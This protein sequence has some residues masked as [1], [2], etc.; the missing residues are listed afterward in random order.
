[1]EVW[2]RFGV[3]LGLLGVLAGCEA[4]RPRRPLAQ[5]KSARWMAN[6]GLTVLDTLCVRLT[7]GALAV[8][9]ALLA[10]RQTWGV[11][12]LLHVPTWG[13]VLLSIIA[14][15]FAIYLQ[16]VAFHANP[17]LWRLH[18]VHHTDRDFDVTTGLR[19]HPVEIVLSML[20]KAAV[21]L[22]LGAHPAAVVAFEVLLNAT[23]QFNHSNVR[24]PA[25]LERWLR[26]VL[27]TPDVHRMHHSVL[28]EE[29]Q[30]NFGFSVPFW[31]RLCGTY[32]ERPARP[33]TTMPLGVEGYQAS[34]PLGLLR[35]LLL[36]FR[37]LVVY[38]N[39]LE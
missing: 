28:G 8:Q 4:W 23:S 24:L 5:S 10:Q 22:C 2:V 26:Y 20:Y 39:T 15:D 19:F 16:H 18:L 21:V 3:F 6:L 12:P 36:P 9:A 37:P 30:S 7:I 17:L 35:L 14:L 13:N 27:I 29:M 11:L 32:R 38:A 25:R 33:Q 34:R 31:D 1:M